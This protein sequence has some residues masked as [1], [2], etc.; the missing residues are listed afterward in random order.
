MKNKK[1]RVLIT[2]AT[3]YIGRRLEEKLLNEENVRLFVRNINKVREN[4]KA[5]VEIVEGDTFNKDALARA[6]KNV[7]IAFYLI[8]SLGA[9]K[10]FEKL[11]QISAENFREACI[12]AG[13]EKIIYLG[14]LGIK[15]TASKHLLSRIRTGEILSAKPEK[16][17]TIWFRAAI[18]VGSG[19]ISFEILRNLIQEFPIMIVPKWVNTKTQPICVNDVLNYLIAAIH[20]NI[21]GNIVVDIG[22]EQMSF[23]QML[24][25]TAKVMNLKRHFWIP[26]IAVP[27]FTSM[28][29]SYWIAIFT[30]VPFRITFPLVEGLHSETILQNDNALKYFPNIK[31]VLFEEAITTAIKEIENDQVMSRWCDSSAGEVCDIKYQDDLSQAVFTNRKVVDFGHLSP[32]RVFETA[33]TVGGEVGWFTYHFLWVTRGVMDKFFGGCGLNRGRRNTR[34]LRV[35]DALDFW[36]VVDIKKNKRLLLL[37]QLWLPGKGWLEFDIEDCKLVQTAYFYPYGILGR[38]YWYI[39]MPFHGIIF[40]DLAKHIIKVAASENRPDCS[41]SASQPP[42]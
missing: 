8:H 13:V 10:G 22:S 2:G 39:F 3:G 12:E 40:R 28:L 41:G 42:E 5:K 18:I 11:E 20:S 17:Q 7:D 9:G 24:C 23:K 29:S 32:S 30:P 33:I 34:E 38:I 4:T 35:G 1:K 27:A 16:I 14:G 25:R 21:A 36:K 31:P 37:G 19:S 26:P 15:K 6:V